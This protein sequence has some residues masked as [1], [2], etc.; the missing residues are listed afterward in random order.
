MKETSADIRTADFATATQLLDEWTKDQDAARVAQALGH[1]S[2]IIRRRAADALG[3]IGD[4]AAVSGLIE[5]LGQNQVVYGG[6]T[7]DVILQ[8]ELNAALITSLGKLTGAD[9]GAPDPSS[10]QDVWRV[11]QV[12]R[13]WRRPN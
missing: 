2:L 6:G 4:P 13:E 9:F 11:L 7:E 10:R 8:K 12:S 1:P 5:A 3:Q